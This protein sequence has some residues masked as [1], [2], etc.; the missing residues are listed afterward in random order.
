MRGGLHVSQRWDL[1][2][3]EC[4]LHETDVVLLNP[5]RTVRSLVDFLQNHPT[6]RI[7]IVEFEVF[8]FQLPETRDVQS[9]VK[10]SLTSFLT[11]FFLDLSPSWHC[12]C[13]APARG[14]LPSSSWIHDV[15]FGGWL[16]TATICSAITVV[17]T[18]VLGTLTNPR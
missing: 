18:D 6:K 4:W 8:M 9:P 3:N 14:V 17:N 7:L 5:P 12:D 16:C 15:G 1:S 11:H 10:S 2:A 13:F